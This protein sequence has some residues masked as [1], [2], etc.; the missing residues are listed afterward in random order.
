MDNP[1]LAAIGAHF[2]YFNDPDTALVISRAV[3]GLD[4]IAGKAKVRPSCLLML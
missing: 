3:S 4:I 2:V 1:Y